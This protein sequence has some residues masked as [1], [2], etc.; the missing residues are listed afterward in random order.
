VGCQAIQRRSE[1]F[2]ALRLLQACNR[3]SHALW[4]DGILEFVRL[5][6]EGYWRKSRRKAREP[7]SRRPK[8][9]ITQPISLDVLGQIQACCMT[10]L[11]EIF[12]ELGLSQYLDVFV[13]QGFETWD[14]ILDITESDL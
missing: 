1:A 3:S 4:L 10:E 6:P 9:I 7:C 11:G 5:N 12:E 8:K 14:T 13:E 2:P